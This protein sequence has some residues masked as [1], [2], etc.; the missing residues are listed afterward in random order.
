VRRRLLAERL[1]RVPG[2]KSGWA[3]T[4]RRVA[5]PRALSEARCLTA[6]APASTRSRPRTP[7]TTPQPRPP[8]EF[9]RNNK[10]LVREAGGLRALARLLAAAAEL[11]DL[12]EL[13]RLG[14]APAVAQCAGAVSQLAQDC[15]ENQRHLLSAD[16]DVLPVL[17]RCVPAPPRLERQATSA[18]AAAACSLR[19]HTRPWHRPAPAA[20][21]TTTTPPPPAPRTP[22]PPP[23]S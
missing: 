7:L 13:P 1:R 8:G 16:V 12:G 5:L 14:L 3:T 22:H 21:F 10:I 17:F 15:E 9:H 20:A 2:Q 19:S 11:P 18:A 23:G 4:T 6:P